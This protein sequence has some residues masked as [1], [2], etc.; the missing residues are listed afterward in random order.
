[1]I[2]DETLVD[3]EEDP[4]VSIARF[5]VKLNDRSLASSEVAVTDRW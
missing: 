1:M 2:R 4:N 3:W 5:E